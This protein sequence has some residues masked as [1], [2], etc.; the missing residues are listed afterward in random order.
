MTRVLITGFGPF[1]GAPSN[2]TMRI[3][4]RLGS[5]RRVGLQNTTRIVRLLPTTW[6]MLDDVPGMLAETRPDL[7]LMFGLAGRRQKIT[8]ERRAINQAS[9]LRTDAVGGNPASA[10]LA[11]GQPFAMR[12]SI[13]PVRL[14]A[15]LRRAGLPAAP[16]NTAGDYLC[17]ALSWHVLASGIPAVFIHVPRPRRM[18]RP[19]A[20]RK[21]ARPGMADLQRAAEI[22]LTES[23]R[24][25]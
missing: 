3:A 14:V 2:P 6:A 7:V 4:R 11:K 15:A 8:P 22:L 1:P 12:S 16:S 17:N 13:D 23:L 25:K 9:L 24:Q 19:L 21:H 18:G 10:L 5:L 20:T